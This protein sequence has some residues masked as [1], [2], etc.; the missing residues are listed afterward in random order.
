M[1][2]LFPSTKTKPRRDKPRRQGIL[3]WLLRLGGVLILVFG[4]STTVV[5]AQ[6]DKGLKQ[7]EDQLIRQIVPLPK[8][9]TQAPVYRPAP[10]PPPRQA[11]PP[12]EPEPAPRRE[13]PPP[14]PA[15]APRQEAPPPEP[16]PEPEPEPRREAAPARSFEPTPEPEPASSD[17]DEPPAEA[18]AKTANL[19]S[20]QYTLEF[21]RSPVVGN[22]FR[23][24]GVYAESRLGFTRPRSWK[25]QSVKALIRFQH[26]PAL[27]ASRSNLTLRVNGTSIGSVPLNRKAS[28]VGQASFTIPANLIQDYNDLILVAQQNNDPKCSNPS[29]TT[30]WTEILP[31][32]KLIFGYQA[33]PIPLNLSRYPYPFFDDLSLDTNRLAYLL[34]KA[35]EAWLTAA[36]RLQAAL[37]R[38]ADF[39]PIDTRIVKNLNGVKSNEHLVIIGTPSDQP[40]LKSLAL[41][42]NIANNQLLDGNKSPLAEDVG[43]LML[44]TTQKGSVPV[45]VITGN[46]AEGVVKAAQFLVQPDAT[47]IGTGAAIVVNE[48]KPIPSP[49]PRNW[50]RYLPEKNAFSLQEIKKQ[51]N[52]KPIEDITVRGSG[53]PPIE[54]DFRALPDDQFTRGSSMTLNYSYGPQVNPRTSALEVLLD[55]N[56]I[57]GARLNSEAGAMRQSLKVDLPAN[58]IKPTSKLQVAFRLNPREPGICGDVTDQQLTGTLHSDTSFNLNRQTSVELPNLELLQ[59]GF[60]FA[61]PQ[62]LST[63]TLVVPKDPTDT[64]LLTLLTFSERLGRLSQADSVKLTAYTTD[65]LPAEVRKQNHL[66]GIGTRERFPF[67]EALESGNFKLSEAFSRQANQAN[68]QA[69]A[70]EQGVIKEV[71]NNENSDRVI[72]ALSGQTEQGLEKVQQVIKS[73]PWFF[74]LREDTVLV[75]ANDQDAP[76]YQADA[77]KLE[78]LE[79]APSKRRIENTNPLAQVSRF[80]QENWFL[81]PLGMIA[82][83][84]LLYGIAQLYL[85]RFSDKKRH[86]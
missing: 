46:G 55:N 5:F 45:L 1:K 9:P 15:P 16:A 7:Q 83:A 51:A 84:L 79:R 62:D 4:I 19:P 20:G 34:P 75:A 53:A 52:G 41:P 85:K 43:V 63:T 28:Q 77:F 48:L 54:I 24:R 58:L 22:R 71:L 72:L 81:L 18:E 37:G 8:A 38:L 59:S 73:D 42:F 86:N 66:V 74:Q 78:F 57:G 56:F 32:S 12:P 44:A 25:V 27:I 68:I 17:D 69:L 76:S 11:A 35:N 23:L 31:D 29:D 50:P 33:Q 82:I 65:V 70:D 49:S 60:P 3:T 40:A 14:E 10:A 36:P 61:T 80:L 67:P 13:A 2:R 30:L 26:S 6:S 21:N 64:D 39:R 47:K